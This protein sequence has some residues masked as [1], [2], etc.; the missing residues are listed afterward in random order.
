MSL[1]S[2][3]PKTAA[4]LRDGIV[5]GLHL[6]AQIYVS[7]RGRTVVDAAVGESRPGEPMTEGALMLWLSAAKPIAAVAIAQL[8]QLGQLNLDDRI[9]RFIPEF[10]I[11]GKEPITLRHVLTHTGGFR[12]APSPKRDTGA[13]CHLYF[14]CCSTA[15]TSGT[16]PAESDAKAETRFVHRSCQRSPK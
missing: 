7:H 12:A 4:I 9:T 3:L 13:A 14:P 10:G 8:W 11:K 5:Q 6:G 2:H 16:D 15:C 1:Q